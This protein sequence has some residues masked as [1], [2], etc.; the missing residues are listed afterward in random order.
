MTRTRRDAI[1]IGGWEIFVKLPAH[2]LLF[3]RLWN[4]LYLGDW[5]EKSVAVVVQ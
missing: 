4:G 2:D 3:V 1:L 5:R